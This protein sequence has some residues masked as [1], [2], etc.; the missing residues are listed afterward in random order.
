M[1]WKRMISYARQRHFV[2]DLLKLVLDG[3]AVS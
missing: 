3:I 1:H 2:A